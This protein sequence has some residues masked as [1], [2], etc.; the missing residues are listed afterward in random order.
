MSTWTAS[1]SVR[2]ATSSASR[3][4]DTSLRSSRHPVLGALDLE[5]ADGQPQD[6]SRLSLG[7]GQQWPMALRGGGVVLEDLEHA[8]DRGQRRAH[9]VRERRH[10]RPAPAV[11]ALQRPLRGA[12]RAHALLDEGSDQG[13]HRHHQD[14][15]PHQPGPRLRR[16]Q[17]AGV[18]RHGHGQSRRQRPAGM[19]QA[20]P[21]E[22]EDEQRSDAGG[23]PVEDPPGQPEQ[24]EHGGRQGQRRAGRPGRPTEG[25]RRDRRRRGGPP[26]PTRPVPSRAGW[27]A[28]RSA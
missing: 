17:A 9:V 20:Q 16:D 15:R 6:A 19:V 26:R 28:A 24:H 7:T 22:D 23:E 8:G 18:R 5:H 25:R 4:R 14:R 12:H 10:Q 2:V 1:A 11:L 13:G 27:S 21:A 3:S